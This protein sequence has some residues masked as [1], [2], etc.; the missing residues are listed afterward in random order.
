MIKKK[1]LIENNAN[2]DSVIP[3][4]MIPKIA[5]K[6]LLY[7]ISSLVIYLK[8]INNKYISIGIPIVA[9]IA[10]NEPSRGYLIS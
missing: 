4:K 7:R 6:Y 3:A 1:V 5:G 10:N 2:A 9:N 8:Y